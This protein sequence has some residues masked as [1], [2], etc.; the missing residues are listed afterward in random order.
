MMPFQ[1]RAG[2]LVA[3]TTL[4][5]VFCLAGLCL[6]PQARAD[7]SDVPSV[8]EKSNP[9]LLGAFR[10]VV[11]QSRQS[12]VRVKCD[13]RISALGT[14][15]GSDGWVLTKASQLTGNAVVRLPSGRELPATVIGVQEKNDLAL[16]KINARGLRAVEWVES[17][18]A[19][20]GNWVA[21]PGTGPD[22]VAVGVVSVAARKLGE[23]K[24]PF[25]ID[26][27]RGYLG[28]VLAPQDEGVKIGGISSDAPAAKAGLKVDDVL[29]SVGSTAIK[30]ME[31]LVEAL[32]NTK[33]GDVIRVRVRR[34][35]E[36]K[37]VRVTLGK[38][39]E[40]R[41]DFQNRLGSELSKRRKGFPIILQHDL[42]IKPADCGGPL[43]DL[44]GRVIGINIARAGRTE[45]YALP[46]EVVLPLLRELSGGK[47]SPALVK[48][49][50]PTPVN[51]KK[52]GGMTSLSKAVAE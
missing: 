34:D 24:A 39:P 1:S 2:R 6:A 3:A 27:T 11:F 32:K 41:A 44:D 29:L 15:V 20:V 4:A 50:T 7:D 52:K 18:A 25:P 33:P 36:E 17:A 26:P 51:A 9:R 23:E 47:L 8:F 22:P 37:E 49:T 14:V 48:Q 5:P 19:P 30:N 46:S 45:S 40:D 12:T 35:G 31:T 13:G 10:S 43:V 21:A 16:L 28:I 42:V 38:R